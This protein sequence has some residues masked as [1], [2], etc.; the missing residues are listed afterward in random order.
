MD[1]PSGF[2]DWCR[3]LTPRRWFLLLAVFAA[4]TVFAGL[5]LRELWYGDETRVAGIGADVA[6][7]G[8]WLAPR[9]L[10][11]P[12]L[13]YPPL[14]YWLTGLGLKIFGWHDW[15]AKLP[16]AVAAFGAALL[17]FRWCRIG[18]YSGRAGFLAGMMLVTSVQ[19]FE[20]SRMCMVD[21]LLA[22]S[23]TLAWVGFADWRIAGNR[24]GIAVAAAGVALGMLTKGMVGGALAGF[25]FGVFLIADSALARRF[26]PGPYLWT[27]LIGLAAL[28]PVAVW[29]WLLYENEGPEA[30]HQ[31]FVVNGPGRF[32]GTQGDH[33]KPWY[34]YLC[35]FPQLFWPWLPLVPF[36]LWRAV[37][38][39]RN[40]RAALL[41]LTA[42]VTPL[43][44]FSCAAGKRQV[45]LLPIYA[46]LAV[47]CA[48][49]ADAMLD[50]FRLVW[51][52]RARGMALL[53][54]VALIYIGI[55]AGMALL[56]R[57][58]SIR[59]LFEDVS[60]MRV[61]P[62][63][64]RIVIFAPFERLFGAAVYYLREVPEFVS[65]PEEIREGDLVLVM[66]PSTPVQGCRYVE[67]AGRTGI[68]SGPREACVRELRKLKIW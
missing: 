37:R 62:E 14:Y 8:H 33:V 4:V 51:L 20:N 25:G 63:S 57:R 27:A 64:G 18:G 29:G 42:A 17:A 54:A 16:S 22:A 39:A 40:D 58:N 36:A 7:S 23:L 38:N 13:E 66:S 11:I 61:R 45:Y 67:Y 47:L 52:T 9:L 53:A 55:D 31:A 15:A 32:S 24:R 26:R 1:L 3:G 28:I 10:H 65:E 35:R 2:H 5:G 41:V 6:L 60:V 19:F 49:W 56:N 21:M 48:I 68:L 46:P 50:R 59:R 30:F 44:L 34:F 43:V 12:F